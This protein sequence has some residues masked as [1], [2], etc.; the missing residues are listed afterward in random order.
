MSAE[1]KALAA[2]TAGVIAGVL[3]RSD[4]PVRGE[5]CA[6]DDVAEGIVVSFEASHSGVRLEIVV[7]EA[8]S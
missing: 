1:G 4:S 2:F 3:G 6:V 8:G 7:R 5:V